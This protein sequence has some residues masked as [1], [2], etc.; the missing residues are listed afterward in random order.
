[1]AQWINMQINGWWWRTISLKSQNNIFIFSS[2]ELHKW[3]Q[4]NSIRCAR[5]QHRQQ[6]TYEKCQIHKSY[7]SFTHLIISL[8]FHWLSGQT[9]FKGCN[10]GERYKGGLVI[11]R[12]WYI[13]WKMNSGE[14]IGLD[15]FDFG[16]I[17][18]RSIRKK[19][20]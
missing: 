19:K 4:L 5:I 9:K 3:L 14:Y 17:K 7:S 18:T 8:A 20:K 15:G 12:F 2:E 6:G 1:M 16:N 13:S 10:N 11:K